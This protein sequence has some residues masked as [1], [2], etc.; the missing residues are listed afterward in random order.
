MATERAV[1]LSSFGIREGPLG[2][3]DPT[4]SIFAAGVRMGRHGSESQDRQ[5]VLHPSP[6]LLMGV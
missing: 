5:T 6:F 3:T 1:M 4:L 2:H